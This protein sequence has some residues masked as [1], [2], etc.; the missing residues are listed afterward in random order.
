[1]CV[2]CGL[3]YSNRSR[4]RYEAHVGEHLYVCMCSCGYGHFNRKNV[5]EHHRDQ[6]PD[7]PSTAFCDT[8]H[9]FIVDE[10]RYSEWQRSLAL[11]PH[12]MTSW[13]AGQEEC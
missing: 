9:L 5:T 1:M 11:R 2:M 4:H 3:N 7:H 8:R 12:R 6:V 13:S 10:A